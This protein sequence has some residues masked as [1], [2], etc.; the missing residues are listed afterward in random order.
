[1]LPPVTKKCISKVHVH[2]HEDSVNAIELE[3][4]DGTKT[5]LHGQALGTKKEF[6][7]RK[8]EDIVL[9][10]YIA[11]EKRIHGLQFKTDFGTFSSEASYSGL[12]ELIVSP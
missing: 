4:S 3:F 6:V 12:R 10:R 5:G 11:D 9:V 2:C 1:M 8:D 7:L